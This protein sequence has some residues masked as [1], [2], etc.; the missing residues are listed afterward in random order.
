MSK[1]NLMVICIDTKARTVYIDL[2]S[3]VVRN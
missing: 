1:Y 2:W 3:M